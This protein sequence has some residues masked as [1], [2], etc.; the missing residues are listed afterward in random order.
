MKVLLLCGYR[1]LHNNAVPLGMDPD[2]SGESILLDHQLI[3]L[4]G[5]GL[6]PVC[7]LSGPGADDLLRSSRCLSDAEL[8]YDT[9]ADEVGLAS[10]VKAG[11]AAATGEGCFILPVEIPLPPPPV[12]IH[13]KESWRRE[14][15]HTS[16]SHILQLVKDSGEPW[17][18][19]FPLLVTRKGNDVIQSLSPFRSLVDTRLKYLAV[20]I[21]READLASTENAL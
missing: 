10:N 19:G 20:S 16:S 5:L 21:R 12:W 2:P 3:G 14:G 1:P 18:L 8:V 9:N 4:R 13:L 15:L 11:L 17:G 6:S 7:V